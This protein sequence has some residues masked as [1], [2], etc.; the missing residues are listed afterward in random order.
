[1]RVAFQP[2]E[3]VRGGRVDRLTNMRWMSL[4]AWGFDGPFQ[5]GQEVHRRPG[6]LG[7]RR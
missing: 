2:G 7:T 6:W 4:P 3:H 1:M 5:E